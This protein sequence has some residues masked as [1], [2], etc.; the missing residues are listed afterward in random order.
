MGGNVC[1]LASGMLKD[2]PRARR[3][4]VLGAAF[5]PINIE[6]ANCVE[7]SYSLGSASIAIMAN[8]RANVNDNG[9]E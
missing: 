8:L 9:G 1:G 3:W 5:V 6:V 7:M 2:G 4:A